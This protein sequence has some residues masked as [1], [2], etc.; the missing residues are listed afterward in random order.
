M[1]KDWLKSETLLL[2]LGCP[3]RVRLTYCGST[4]GHNALHGLASNLW[5]KHDGS[6]LQTLV[7]WNVVCARAYNCCVNEHWYTNSRV[8]LLPGPVERCIATLYN[9]A[10]TSH[11]RFLL[12]PTTNYDSPPQPFPAIIVDGQG[13]AN[14]A[15]HY[16]NHASLASIW[17]I[18][19]LTPGTTS[20]LRSG[21]IGYSHGIRNPIMQ[22]RY[23]LHRSFYFLALLVRLPG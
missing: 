22:G 20:R 2:D 14:V 6:R 3:T 21:P 8:K 4:G 10:N 9:Q 19:Q 1:Q 11:I 5:F 12:P 13:S 16:R 15:P 23:P 18:R 17:A 7:H